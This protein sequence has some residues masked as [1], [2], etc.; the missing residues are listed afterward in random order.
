LEPKTGGTVSGGYK[1]V[2][3]D[4]TDGDILYTQE[5]GTSIAAKGLDVV[6]FDACYEGMMEVAYEI[7]NHASYM[8]GS[9]DTEPGDGWEYHL[10]LENFKASSKTAGDLLSAIVDAYETRYSTTAETTLSAID[11]SE[12]DN[13]MTQLNNFTTALYNAAT[14]NVIRNNMN[15]IIW[16][17]AEDYWSAPGDLNIDIW[18]FADEMLTRSDYADTEAAA[19]KTAIEAAV[20]NEWHHSTGNPDSHGLALHYIPLD[21]G[22]NPSSHWTAYDQSYTGLY[23]VSFVEASTW[24]PDFTNENGLLFRLWYEVY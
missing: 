22:G 2:C 19:L 6:G 23:P 3:S 21:S 1:A 15:G 5:I 8:I 20:V 12:I 18:D 24:A 16:E 14:T 10:W 9:E 11:L 13:V 17:Y 4:D 7:R